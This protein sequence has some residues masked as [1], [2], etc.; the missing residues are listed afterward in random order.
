M[1]IHSIRKSIT[2]KFI[3][4]LMLMLVVAIGIL[5]VLNLYTQNQLVNQEEQEKLDN[6]GVIFTSMLEDREQLALTL[7]VQVAEMPEVQRAFALQDRARLQEILY[8]SYIALDEQFGVPQAQFH[9]PPAT[10]FLRL[11]KL[12][13]FGDDLSGFRNT[14]LVANQ[15][16]R[17]VSGLEKGR[18]GYGVRGV[19]PISY[20]GEHVGTFEMGLS[21]GSE[22]LLGFRDAYGSEVSVFSFEDVSKVTSFEEEGAEEESGFALFASS[23]EEPFTIPEVVRTRVFESGEPEI[24]SITVQRVPYSVLV[25]PVRDYADDIVAVAE[26]TRSRAE[27]AASVSHA[28]NL[29]ILGGVVIVALSGLLMALIS[30]RSITRP[31]KE[32]LTVAEEVAAGRVLG[33]QAIPAGEDEIGQLGAA[34]QN[35]VGYIQSV[36]ETAGT[37]AEGDLSRNVDLQS[38]Q[39]DLGIAFNRMLDGLK[40]L[41]GE[42]TA[43]TLQLTRTADEVATATGQAAEA[44]NQVATTI[45]QVA[46]GTQSQTEAVTRTMASVDMMTKSIDGVARGAQEQ[47]QEITRAS[48]SAAEIST[49]IT[50]TATDAMEGVEIAEMAAGIARD[51]TETVEKTIKGMETIREKVNLSADK[52]KNMGESSE[53]IGEIVATIDDIASQTNLLAL[54]AAI[55][56]ARAG[57]H[58]KGFAVV[59]DEVRKLA[60]RSTLATQEIGS[61]I[62]EVQDTITE[63]I[64]A[65]RES[66]EEV[67]IGTKRAGEAGAALVKI[68]EAA[69]KVA[70]QVREISGT[71]KNVVKSSENLGAAMQSVSA[72]VEENTAATEEMSG[73]SSQVSDAMETIASISE[74]NSAAVEEVSAGTEEMSAQVEEVTAAAQSLA[75]MA[76][77]LQ[78][79]V[80]RFRLNNEEEAAESDNEAPLP[81]PEGMALV[82]GNGS[83]VSV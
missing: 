65:M 32:L 83:S 61:L 57:E 55:E 2:W 80:S 40:S 78:E 63:S 26:I 9:L 38:D 21:F 56:A 33:I 81:D 42:V 28:R 74:E 58:G 35:I 22:F 70:E 29:T 3:I 37:I 73:G 46:N 5:V 11:H 47:A 6:L 25:I 24:I 41:V 68:R 62:L 79:A 7:A 27:T 16:Q 59:A 52:V 66:T 75:E 53:K 12:E 50:R 82:S 43:N 51:G 36:T 60:E 19:V 39:D 1:H 45:Q 71:A 48:E 64:T 8:D 76:E 18:A 67:D 54:N 17:Q 49:V 13:K 10:S 14:V 20:E 15:E 77:I 31:V 69:E 72:I 44:T 30:T 4:P 23:L 34:F